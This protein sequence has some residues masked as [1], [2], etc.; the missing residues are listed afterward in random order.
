MSK[1]ARH[2]MTV[3][4]A[5]RQS[6][7]DNTPAASPGWSERALEEILTATYWFD[8]GAAAPAAMTIRFSGQRTGLVGRPGARARFVRDEAVDGIVAGSGPVSVTSRVD[9]VNSGTWIVT[10]QEVRGKGLATKHAKPTGSDAGRPVR[11]PW[12]WMMPIA[13]VTDQVHTALRPLA[14]IPGVIPGAWLVLV[15][16][17]ITLALA[18]Q[19]ALHTPG[20]SSVLAVSIAAVAGG[21]I[22][23]KSWYIAVHR[24]RRYDGWCIQGFIAGA[25]L[26]GTGAL[27][28]L[29]LPVGVILDA[30]APGLFLGVALGRPGCF[31]AGCCSGRP[32]TSRWGLWSSDQRIG[33]RRIPTQLLESLL[34]LIIG[35]TALLL[36][37]D[38]KPVA[39]GSIFVGALAA[40]TLGRQ[41][42]LP[43]RS[44]LR[45]RSSLGRSLTVTVAALVL[46]GDIVIATIA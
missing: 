45:L 18:V 23:A 14:R 33:A 7:A 13:P 2:L 15:T 38:A 10:A 9:G 31:L 25:A 29:R 12:P 6:R 4:T 19:A 24:G 1:G 37:V 46:I 26:V 44:E 32:T 16:F 34:G 28:L 5:L 39:A 20:H 21:A 40:Y 43:H 8:P 3:P 35:G 22:A 30:T 42:I 36:V 27:L 41:F 11:R 17:G